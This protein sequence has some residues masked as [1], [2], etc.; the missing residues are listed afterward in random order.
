MAT[1]KEWEEDLA[2]MGALETNEIIKAL[3]TLI[4]WRFFHKEF[5][6][7]T[8]LRHLTFMAREN[9]LTMLKAQAG[10]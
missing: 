5:P 4:D 8:T 9:K 3:N 7:M 6:E 10:A 1:V 2:K